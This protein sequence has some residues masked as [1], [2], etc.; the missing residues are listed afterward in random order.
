MWFVRNY[1]EQDPD[2]E[3][4]LLNAHITEPSDFSTRYF[5]AGGNSLLW[6]SDL[7]F[8]QDVLIPVNKQKN[9]NKQTLT[10]YIQQSY[11]DTARLSGL[12]ISGDITN[13]GKPDGFSMADEFIDSLNRILKRPLS[14]ESIIFCPGNH[15]F[16]RIEGELGRGNP[17]LL[18]E[19]LI[20][21]K[22]I[23]NSIIKSIVSMLHYY[24]PL[25][26]QNTREYPKNNSYSIL[27]Q[28][29]INLT[30]SERSSWRY[31]LV[32]KT[33]LPFWLNRI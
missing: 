13:C 28:L 29:A 6:V 20:M 2:H 24:Y 26:N 19:H 15:D 33:L 22:I 12:L 3:I 5:E 8:D 27:I 17:V 10:E 18:T 14:S 23:E 11:A 31:I 7:H 30:Q 1:T 32:W 21:L 25:S 4:K 9:P 16:K